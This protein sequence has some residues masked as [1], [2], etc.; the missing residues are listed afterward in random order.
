MKWGQTERRVLELVAARCLWGP[1]LTYLELGELT[2]LSHRTLQRAVTALVRARRVKR[3]SP[4]KGS[5]EV[6]VGLAKVSASRATGRGSSRASGN[7]AQV[8][9]PSSSSGAAPSSPLTPS[10]K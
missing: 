1:G 6:R 4:S 5:T 9:V 7:G 8:T 2:G 3:I 10:R